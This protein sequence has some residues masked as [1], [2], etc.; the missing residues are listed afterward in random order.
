MVCGW[1][2]SMKI[3][4]RSSA[5][6]LP[7]YHVAEFL[8]D[9]PAELLAGESALAR[10]NRRRRSGGPGRRARSGGV[11]RPRL[12]TGEVAE[13]LGRIGGVGNLRPLHEIAWLQVLGQGR[14]AEEP[15]ADRHGW[16]QMR[17]EAGRPRTAGCI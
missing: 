15:G 5:I 11:R 10:G 4:E 6:A 17:V 3:E 2:W 14:A 13:G 1:S 16:R 12:E 8:K 7:A 9:E